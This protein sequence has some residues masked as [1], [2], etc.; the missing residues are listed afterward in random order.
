MRSGELF[1]GKGRTRQAPLY[2]SIAIATTTAFST[3]RRFFQDVRGAASVGPETTN[4]QRAGQVPG[5]CNFLAQA[6]RIVVSGAAA[7]IRSLN[8]NI[9]FQLK[10]G[11]ILWADA[12][13]EYFSAGMGV[14]TAAANGVP[15][16]RSAGIWD[17]D[18]AR[19][20]DSINFTL[21]AVGTTWTTTAAFFMR[22]YLEGRIEE[23]Q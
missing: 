14:N 1:T 6:L 5:G 11:G 7:D 18:P 9:T 12:P 3:I 10:I 20:D 22:A 4:M 17:L 2:S 8:E 23:P 15:D 16:F 21:E 19:I 13:A